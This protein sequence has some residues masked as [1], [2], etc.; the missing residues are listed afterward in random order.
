MQNLPINDIIQYLALFVFFIL[1][2]YAI[3]GDI[4]KFR[5]RDKLNI[6]IIA[7]FFAF[8]PFL[9]FTSHD[10]IIHIAYSIGIFILFFCFFALGLIA[11]GD[12]KLISALCLWIAPENLLSF[13]YN[14]SVIGG[15]FGIILI[16]A[17]A[18]AKAKGLPK[19]PRWLRQ[20][21][22]AKRAMPYGVAIGL[23]AITT[24]PTFSW[25]INLIK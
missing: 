20:I 21:L 17:R 18:I 24:M 3:I 6:A 5:I 9:G 4:N 2:I 10:I 1:S 23:G 14:M 15:I 12:V 13:F 7:S 16:I 19:K 11:P 25:V 22:R 8:A